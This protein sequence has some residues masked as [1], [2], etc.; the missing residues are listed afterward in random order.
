MNI[1]IIFSLHLVGNPRNE[2]RHRLGR[3]E[4]HGVG[5][6]GALDELPAVGGEGGVPRAGGLHPAVGGIINKFIVYKHTTTDRHASQSPKNKK[7]KRVQLKKTLTGSWAR[8]RP[9]QG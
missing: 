1:Y 5:V 8:S 4:E 9:S 6:H 3:G 2:A 7:W